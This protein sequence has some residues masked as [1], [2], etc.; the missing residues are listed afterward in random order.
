MKRVLLDLWGLLVCLVR[1]AKEVGLVEMV[2]EA[3]QV[4]QVTRDFQDFLDCLGC[5]ERKGIGACLDQLDRSGCLV[6]MDP[7]VSKVISGTWVLLVKWDQEVLWDHEVPLDQLGNL[8]CPGQKVL[9]DQKEIREAPVPMVPLVPPDHKVQRGHRDPLDIWDHLVF[10]VPRENLV[11]LDYPAQLVHQV[12][13]ELLV[14]LA[15]RVKLDPLVRKELM[16][17]QDHVV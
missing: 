15:L 6:M 10:L 11:Y 12:L 3:Y 1:L 2:R 14:M 17:I 5:P 13:K 7:K 9:L 16:V 4:L 8:V